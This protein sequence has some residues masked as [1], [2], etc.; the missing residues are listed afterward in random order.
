MMC[1]KILVGLE[2][3]KT[4]FGVING[5]LLNF[6]EV[7]LSLLSWKSLLFS[8]SLSAVAW[9][10]EALGFS[11]II[12]NFAGIDMSLELVSKAVFIFCF[13]SILGFVSLFPGGLGVAEGGFTGMLI[14]LLGLQ[15]SQAVAS[16]I[17]LRLLTLW[18]GVILGLIAFF[19]LFKLLSPENEKKT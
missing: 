16:T 8:T 14:F 17:L 2:N 1:K 3:K 13:V 10:A 5:K 19:A 15:K 12:S 4:I 11:L 18:W 6:R 9:F 7:L